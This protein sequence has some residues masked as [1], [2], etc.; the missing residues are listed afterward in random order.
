MTLLSK[1]R[2]AEL[3]KNGRREAAVERATRKRKCPLPLLRV[4][5]TRVSHIRI[6][7]RAASEHEAINAAEE[8]YLEIDGD[9]PRFIVYGG[10]AFNAVSAEKLSN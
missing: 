6:D 9:D 7:L 4:C 2:R 1:A 5:F 10:D 3:L 8:L